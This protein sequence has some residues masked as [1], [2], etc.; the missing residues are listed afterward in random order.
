[1]TLDT[2]FPFTYVGST[3]DLESSQ[4]LLDAASVVGLDCEWQPGHAKASL[5][6]LALWSEAHGARVLLLDL[7]ALGREAQPQ[8]QHLLRAPDV[9]K[10]GFQMAT[11]LRALQ[12]AVGTGSVAEPCVDF[13]TLHAR[14]AAAHAPGVAAP[15]S[16]GLSALCAAQLGL[17]LDKTLQVS[18]WGHRPLSR[19]Q[20]QYAALDAACLLLLLDAYL[21]QLSPA[22][23]PGGNSPCSGTLA[24]HEASAAAQDAAA[25]KPAAQPRTLAQ[26]SFAAARLKAAA[27]HWGQR[28]D[29]EQLPAPKPGGAAARRDHRRG[30]E[31]ARAAAALPGG[32]FPLHVPWMDRQRRLTGRPA[33]IADVMAQGLAR[34]LRLLGFDAEQLDVAPKG[35]RHGAHRALVE[36]AEAEDRVILTADR[37]FVARNLSD[38]AYLVRAQNKHQQL[39][40]VL[41]AFGLAVD[42]DDLLSRCPKCN[43]EF[44]PE[45][46]DAHDL[47]PGHSVPQTVL[48]RNGGISGQGFWVCSR[49]EAVF[50][51][52]C[53]YARAMERLTS[54]VGASLG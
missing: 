51:Q 35:Q 22:D 17:S 37:Q 12:Q 6:S 44:L 34:Q 47:P 15:L 49:C 32:G 45:P 27:E 29:L 24:P 8:L 2:E 54:L 23:Y 40:E 10:L 19:E 42:P 25:L 20:Q 53:Q 18:E 9:L 31:A 46:R 4:E 28:L 11:D 50:W 30:A 14:L 52:G 41:Q 26:V 43:G 13:A 5:V 39:D 7:L 48:D 16:K 33:F 36:R 3:R 38:L 21:R 1:M